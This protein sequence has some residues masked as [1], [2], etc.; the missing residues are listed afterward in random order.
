[1]VETLPD[2]PPITE[3]LPGL[4]Q[5]L[6][7]GPFFGVFVKEGTPDEAVEALRNAYG[8][9]AQQEDFQTLLDQRGYELMNLTGQEAEDFLNQWQSVTSWLMQDAGMAKTS[10]EEFGIARP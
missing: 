3:A 4:A 5:Y 9:A 6:P 1:L 7:W 2:T 10:P 8:E